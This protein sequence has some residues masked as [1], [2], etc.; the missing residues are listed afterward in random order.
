MRQSVAASLRNLR[1]DYIDCLILHSPMKT[2]EETLQVWR[3]MERAVSEGTVRSLGISNAYDAAA[4]A[5]LYDAAEIK[6]SVVQTRLCTTTFRASI[7][8]ISVP[9][10][11]S[12]PLPRGDTPRPCGAPFL[13]QSHG[14]LPGVL[15]AHGQHEASPR[16]CRAGRGPRTWLHTG[17][18][19]VWLRAWHRLR[20]AVGHDVNGAHA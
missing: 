12:E 18:G 10:T 19:L 9:F 1:T 6:P 2:H 17:A 3:E 7:H 16:A 14:L 20:A 11:G 13:S 15:D 4:L 5:R 8:T